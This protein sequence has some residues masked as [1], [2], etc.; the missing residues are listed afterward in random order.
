MVFSRISVGAK[1]G[2]LHLTLTENYT[3]RGLWEVIITTVVLFVVSYATSPPPPEKVQGLTVDWS[4]APRAVPGPDRLAAAAR[5]AADR[6]RV[7]LCLAMVSEHG[8]DELARTRACG[9]L[10]PDP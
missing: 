1:L 9:A 3:F 4:C 10:G 5:A 2:F 7:S 6:H 8:A